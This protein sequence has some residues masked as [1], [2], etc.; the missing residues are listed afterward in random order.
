LSARITKHHVSTPKNLQVSLPC[1]GRVLSDPGNVLARIDLRTVD[2]VT[3][4]GNGEPTL[5][6][7]LGA[8]ARQIK[9]RIGE[10]PMAIL[11]NS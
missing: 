7:E 11:T 5:S 3:F 8:I 6:L 4:F 10:L 9:A 1:P 2:A